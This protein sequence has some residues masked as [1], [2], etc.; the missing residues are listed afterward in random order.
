M[1]YT[2]FNQHAAQFSQM[3]NIYNPE[4]PQSFPSSGGNPGFNILPS[5][6]MTPGYNEPPNFVLQ[7]M[8]TKMAGGYIYSPGFPAADLSANNLGEFQT[9]YNQNEGFVGQADAMMTLTQHIAMLEQDNANLRAATDRLLR[10]G[11]TMS[12]RYAQM[13]NFFAFEVTDNGVQAVNIQNLHPQRNATILRRC[14]FL[15]A[16]YQGLRA[17]IDINTNRNRAFHSHGLRRSSEVESRQQNVHGQYRQSVEIVDLT[18]GDDNGVPRD[19]INDAL[20]FAGARL[21]GEQPAVQASL[22]LA[23]KEIDSG[24]R[25][26]R[27]PRSQSRT[28]PDA[29]SAASST[30][31]TAA[32]LITA[33]PESSPPQVSDDNSLS[34]PPK[35]RLTTAEF[36]AK[37]ERWQGPVANLHLAKALGMKPSP[38][39][40]QEI[41][42]RRERETFD[43]SLRKAE[44]KKKDSRRDNAARKRTVAHHKGL[45][46]KTNNKDDAVVKGKMPERGVSE[47]NSTGS[48]VVAQPGDQTGAGTDEDSD[49]LEAC[50]E[51]YFLEEDGAD[52]EDNLENEAVDQRSTGRNDDTWDISTA[53]SSFQDAGTLDTRAFEDSS[54]DQVAQDSM[55]APH[56]AHDENRGESRLIQQD[57]RTD[58]CDRNSTRS[59]SPLVVE[60]GDG[61]PLSQYQGPATLQEEADDGLDYLF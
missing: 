19:H 10:E 20:C 37:T 21:P 25:R 24:H 59:I 13:R 26:H 42:N 1:D 3:G 38:Q 50:F 27:R 47:R 8:P 57:N 34:Q 7:P 46:A 16:H 61:R 51:E 30:D 9:A 40:A 29:S 54:D 15:V 55:E 33:T 17:S 35:K 5:N 60:D 31:T 11:R 6:G 32:P 28:R 2:G 49:A 39:Y 44:K 56:E 14:D 52:V 23:P 45:V 22:A 4:N 43:L 36:W 18:G 53:A 41:S 12:Q 48:R 58:E